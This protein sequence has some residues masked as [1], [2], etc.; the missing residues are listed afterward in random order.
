MH[1]ILFFTFDYSLITWHESG[2]ITR[3]LKFYNFLISQGIKVTF[4]TFGDSEDLGI[5]HNS[6]INVIPV[7]SLMNKS[8]YKFI[9][10]VKSI[11]IPFH[12]YKVT[13][14]KSDTR[15]IIVKQNQLLGSWVS[16]VFK[17]ISKS[18]LYT[19]TGYD[20]FL[21]SI[22]E[23]KPIYK[24]FLYLMLTQ[25]TIFFS[26][27]YS[28][29]SFSDFSFLKKR[30][31]ATKNMVIRPNWVE[32]GIHDVKREYHNTLLAVGRL[33]KQKNFQ[34]LLYSLIDTGFKL[35]IYGEGSLKEELITLSKELGVDLN[36]YDNIEN[37][38]LLNVYKRYNYFI[39]SATFE[40][41][42][43]VI[44]EAMANGCVVIAKDIINNREIIE[45]SV[46]GILY[47]DNL[48]EILVKLKNNKYDNLNLVNNAKNVIN[49]T[50]SKDV[51]FS[52][53]LFDFKKLHERE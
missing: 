36:I 13:N 46:S 50:Y 17:I 6:K 19:R 12:I 31:L 1:L 51:V 53:Y 44:L 5:L 45:N 52:K 21:F 49:D 22:K 42:S 27:Y 35:D 4:V 7:Y 2:H 10:I 16:I 38:E 24:R 14:T 43:K 32:K 29:T 28:V 26:D 40:G 23:K 48:S 11:S 30:C 15:N 47:T 37:D 41:N 8:K 9:N 39:S 34:N 20:M 33:E 3:E 18:K 25:V